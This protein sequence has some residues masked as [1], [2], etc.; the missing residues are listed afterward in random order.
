MNRYTFIVFMIRDKGVLVKRR[1]VLLRI[2]PGCFT[3]F[4]WIA[5]FLYYLFIE[6]QAKPQGHA[7][8]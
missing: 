2:T 6:E 5:I 8:K 3:E 4:I 7:Q 1:R